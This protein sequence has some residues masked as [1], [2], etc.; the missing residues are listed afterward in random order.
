MYCSGWDDGSALRRELEAHFSHV[1][2]VAQLSDAAAAE[3]IRSHGIDVL[4][5]LNGP[6]RAH[7]MGIL[8]RRPA[9]VQ[10]HYLGWP[11]STGGRG[12]DYLI[13]DDYVIPPGREQDYPERLIRL[14]PTYQVNGYGQRAP[15]PLRSDFGLPEYGPVLGAFNQ[16]RKVGAT[17]WVTWMRILSAVPEATLWLLDPGPLARRHIA[18]F[19]AGRGIDPK[20][21]VVAPPTGQ[22]AHLARLQCCDLMLDPWPYGG[23]TT[24]SDALHAGVPVIALEGT[25]FASRVSGSLLRAA[26]LSALVR[27]DRDAYVR[28]AVDL[29]RH[30][31]K[32]ARVRRFIAEEVAGSPLFD[33]ASRARQ[34]EYAYRFAC[35]RAISGLPPTNINFTPATP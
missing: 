4:V 19:T 20:R 5:D 26:G 17:V 30:P 31:E 35:E 24:T 33:M 11:G 27:P 3:L 10:I 1:H 6:T 9:P 8:V 18:G 23:H 28:T 16:I 34:L 13:A 12:I 2:R 14:V 15:A 25:N 21:I 29:L 32:L 22:V 7:R